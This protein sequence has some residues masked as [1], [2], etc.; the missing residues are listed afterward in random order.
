M[1]YSHKDRRRSYRL[2]G[3]LHGTRSA[4][5]ASPHLPIFNTTLA[6]QPKAPA[7]PRQPTQAPP[8]DALIR[9]PAATVPALGGFTRGSRRSCLS[10]SPASNYGR[11]P[12]SSSSCPP[13]PLPRGPIPWRAGTYTYTHCSTCL[14][15]LPTTIS[16]VGLPIRNSLPSMPV[17]LSEDAQ[18]YER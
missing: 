4:T 11:P 6:S 18:L 12:P 10:V 1:P 2:G 13:S 3:T 9:C 16:C 8:L 14:P 17:S 15:C 7:S 5:V